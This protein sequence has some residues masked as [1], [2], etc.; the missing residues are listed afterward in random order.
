LK[1]NIT[2]FLSTGNVQI[3]QPRD[4][5]VEEAAQ[6]PTVFLKAFP[7]FSATRRNKSRAAHRRCRVLTRRHRITESQNG[8]GWKGPLWVI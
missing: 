7:E 2:S 8:R 3:H 5:A 1:D 4:F 6:K